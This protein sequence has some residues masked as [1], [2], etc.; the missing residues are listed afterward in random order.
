MKENIFDL[1]LRVSQGSQVA[2]DAATIVRSG[3]TWCEWPLGGGSA[4]TGL[5]LVYSPLCPPP[6][7]RR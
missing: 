3:W 1:D 5:G 2:Q 7:D 6:Q 4:A